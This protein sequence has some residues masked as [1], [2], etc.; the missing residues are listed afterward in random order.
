MAKLDDSR[1][2][3]EMIFNYNMVSDLNISYSQIEFQYEIVEATIID[4]TATT[5]EE[6]TTE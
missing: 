5:S 2:I 6:E 4:E 1:L 3:H